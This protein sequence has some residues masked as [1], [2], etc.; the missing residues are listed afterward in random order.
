VERSRHGRVARREGVTVSDSV[1]VRPAQLGD[2]EGMARVVVRSWQET[3]RGLVPDV[4]L[5]D[6]GFLADRERFWTAALTNER[7]RQNRM[8]SPNE[9]GG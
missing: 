3:Y 9:A 5:D 1:V 4:V 6:P 2:V 7:F 8:P